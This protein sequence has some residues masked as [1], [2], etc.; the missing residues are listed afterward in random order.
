MEE[1]GAKVGRELKEVSRM[2]GDLGNKFGKLAEYLIVPNMMEK[3]NAL[4]YEF[5]KTGRNIK[6]A[7]PD[8]K[9]L[10][11]RYFARKRGIRDNCR[12]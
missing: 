11:N 5:T 4:C 3:F 9:T 7:G 12:S 2:V 6:I 1:S 10:R 8:K